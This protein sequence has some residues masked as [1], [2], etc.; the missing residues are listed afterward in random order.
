[1]VASQGGDDPRS[2]I[3][4]LGTGRASSAPGLVEDELP[5]TAGERHPTLTFTTGQGPARRTFREERFG[6]DEPRIPIWASWDS[7]SQ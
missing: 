5:R 3:W 4:A 1:M 2:C 7:G 6:G